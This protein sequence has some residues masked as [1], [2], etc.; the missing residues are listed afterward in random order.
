MT[1]HTVV[2]L[3]HLGT[4]FCSIN[5]SSEGVLQRSMTDQLE[6]SL[7]CAYAQLLDCTW[8]NIVLLWG[9]VENNNG[10]S[11][12]LIIGPLEASWW[13]INASSESCNMCKLHSTES[14]WWNTV[15][16][17]SWYMQFVQK[18][19]WLLVVFM[20]PIISLICA[21]HMQWWAFQFDIES[22]PFF[23]CPLLEFLFLGTCW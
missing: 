12:K 7:L 14:R 15:C 19:D 22:K 10:C 18:T 13:C 4:S 8:K 16:I 9:I 17:S 6:W 1:L 3:R 21:R 11:A 20:D 23:A 2:E 5:L